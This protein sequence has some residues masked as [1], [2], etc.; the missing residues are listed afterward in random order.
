MDMFEEILNEK[1]KAIIQEDLQK[2]MS[3]YEL[4][5]QQFQ[6]FFN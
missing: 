5:T 2:R 6:R 3:K 1:V 4:V